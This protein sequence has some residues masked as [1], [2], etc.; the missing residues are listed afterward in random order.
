M[1]E[2][3]AKAIDLNGG[4]THKET[5]LL[6]AGVVPGQ[7]GRLLSEVVR[8][9]QEDRDLTARAMAAATT[10][11]VRAARDIAW[12]IVSRW[13]AAELAAAE[14][15]SDDDARNIKYAMRVPWQE[16]GLAS[17]SSSST[18]D[19]SSSAMGAGT[20]DMGCFG[21]VVFYNLEDARVPDF[22]KQIEMAVHHGL[23]Y[24]AHRVKEETFDQFTLYWVAVPGDNLNP[25]ALQN[26]FSTM[27]RSHEVPL[28][29]RPDAFL[30]VDEEALYSR[31][32][33]RPYIWL[34]EPKSETETETE[35]K[36]KPEHDDNT[37]TGTGVGPEVEAKAGQ[38]L[39][40]DIKH[41]TPALFA[42]LVQRD[43][44]GDAKRKP[45]RYTSE[46][47]MLHAAAGHSRDAQWERDWIWPPPARYM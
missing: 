47:I 44:E 37:G 10:E 42:R 28:G 40:V 30:Y 46:L 29:L 11:D 34:A 6:S 1:A 7:P 41:I 43:L 8:L 45:Y 25:S 24:L 4:L 39:K 31:E 22:K 3:I 23:H 32:T 36:S 38:P 21:L 12:R 17:S 5:H 14:T 35:P 27:L 2:L 26:R 33:A 13:T 15:L 19:I 16:W 9:S 18:M 20:V